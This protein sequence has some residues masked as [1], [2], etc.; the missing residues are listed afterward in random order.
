[1]A[2][3]SSF[4][5]PREEGLRVYQTVYETALHHFDDIATSIGLDLSEHRNH[6]EA[7]NASSFLQKRLAEQLQEVW[8]QSKKRKLLAA[9]LFLPLVTIP[10]GVRAWK[11]NKKETEAAIKEIR[12][13][14]LLADQE[15]K[16]ARQLCDQDMQGINASLDDYS[17]L[18]VLQKAEAPIRVY[19][20]LSEERLALWESR[21]DVELQGRDSTCVGAISGDVHGN[22]FLLTK[23]HSVIV[24]QK[25]YTGSLEIEWEEEEE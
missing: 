6:L 21:F 3:G 20:R 11:K 15:A 8:R 4:R 13:K 22:P 25:C 5:S 19:P 23:R 18:E 24:S 9:G 16:Q 10:F 12:D 1:M 17:F 7:L 2:D 14:E